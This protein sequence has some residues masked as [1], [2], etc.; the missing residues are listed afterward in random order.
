[1]LDMF[2]SF[3]SSFKEMMQSYLGQIKEMVS[4]IIDA[5][6]G[7]IPKPVT[8]PVNSPVNPLPET[9]RKMESFPER[10]PKI[11]SAHAGI[12]HVNEVDLQAGVI[13]YQLYQK[14]EDAEK[15]FLSKLTEAR[16]KMGPSE[17]LKSA[18]IATQEAEKISKNE[19]EFLYTL[20]HRASQ[21]DENHTEVSKSENGAGTMDL[22]NAMKLAEITLASVIHGKIILEPRPLY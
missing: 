19:A 21:L 10:M 11:L 16:G 20:S 3:I 7:L 12:G 15:F 5:I 22:A 17:A 1:M 18:L 8:P 2:S 13:A 9:P 14:S 6:K 4:S